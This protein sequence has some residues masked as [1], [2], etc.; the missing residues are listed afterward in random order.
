MLMSTGTNPYL[1]EQCGNHI[2]KAHT[3][4]M[5]HRTVLAST[6]QFFPLMPYP[7]REAHTQVTGFTMNA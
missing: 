7:M 2:G 6:L 5:V 1:F 4:L 3:C